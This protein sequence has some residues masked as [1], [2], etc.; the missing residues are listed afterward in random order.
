MVDDPKTDVTTRRQVIKY[1]RRELVAR[2]FWSIASLFFKCSPRIAWRFRVFLL[3]C[4]GARIGNS[5]RISQTVMITMPWN[6]RIGD[7]VTIG[8]RVILY[9]LGPITVKA[10]AVVSQGSHLCAGT[11]DIN[12]RLFSLI[13][14]PVTVEEDVW[15]CADAFVGPNVVVGRGGVVG[16]RAVVVRSTRP[17]AIV[18]G[19]PAQFIKYRLLET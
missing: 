15:I 16:A 5:V 18:A 2:G 1:C 12:D 6:L 19:N 7:Q 8:D 4:F 11:H 9:A 10:R 14:L 13:K 3:R 17:W